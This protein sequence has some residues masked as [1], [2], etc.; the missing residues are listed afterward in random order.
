VPGIGSLFS[1]GVPGF[2]EVVALLAGMNDSHNFMGGTFAILAG[3]TTLN[4]RDLKSGK[5]TGWTTG[6]HFFK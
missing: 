1:V 4:I 2:D 6:V 5:T 3:K